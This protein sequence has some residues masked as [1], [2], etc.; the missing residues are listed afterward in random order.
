[1][2]NN[3]IDDNEQLYRSV[4][5]NP[6]LWETKFHR[7]TSGFFLN[8]AGISVDRDGGRTEQQ[9][10]K[11]FDE[12]YPNRGLVLILA[13]ACREIGTNPVAKPLEDNIYHAEIH[14][15]DGSPIIKSRSKRRKLAVACR[16]VKYPVCA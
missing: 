14:D 7:P 11:D 9:I 16:I 5:K 15:E 10:I 8:P 12:R 1:M 4:P 13:K 3:C 2:L 6:D